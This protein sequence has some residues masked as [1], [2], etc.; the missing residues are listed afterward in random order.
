MKRFDVPG[1]E[2]SV[3]LAESKAA[4]LAPIT[5]NAFGRLAQSLVPL[6]AAM[7]AEPPSLF[8]AARLWQLRRLCVHLV[9][10]D[11]R[12][13]AAPTR[14]QGIEAQHFS[15]V[16]QESLV[17]RKGSRCRHAM[18]KVREVLRLRFE[19]DCS[20]RAIQASTGLSKGSVSEYLKRATTR[21]L[22]W[23]EAQ[24]MNDADVEAYLFRAIGRSEPHGRTPID[25]AGCTPSFEGLG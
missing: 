16:I 4:D 10:L 22:T 5:M 3:H 14:R 19:V 25:L 18:R 7:Q 1:A 15:S 23:P 12:L 8:K 24:S 13:R 17:V 11:Q 9:L 21:G 2:F 6:N 20:H